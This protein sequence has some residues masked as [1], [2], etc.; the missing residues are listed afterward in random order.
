MAD[1]A[2]ARCRPGVLE[3]RNA[4]AVELRGM[5]PVERLRYI[6]QAQGADPSFVTCEAAEALVSLVATQPE[7]L[8]MACRRL[9]E[10]NLAVGPLWWLSARMLRSDE[11]EREG[12]EA[13]R[14]LAYDD[15]AR[16]LAD[17]LD[18]VGVAVVVGW[19]DV[20]A[21]ALRRRGDVEV[22][23]VDWDSQGAQFVRRLND[24]GCEATLVPAS[25]AATA[26]MVADVV[27]VEAFAAG[28]G[29][30]IATPGSLAAA[31][32]A[33][34]RQVPVWVVCGVGRVLP[35]ALWDTL[36]SCLDSSGAEPWDR[37]VELVPASLINAVVG[38]DG[39]TSIH[40]QAPDYAVGVEAALG[41]ST[42]PP[43]PELLRIS[44]TLPG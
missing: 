34:H 37:F 41:Y 16:H 5:N 22:L 4:Y 8:L 7:G 42:C 36:M 27:L 9:I 13:A 29:G 25:G 12:M 24:W 18:D 26:A 35:E 44:E 21:G 6:A 30:V 1:E 17:S 43:A 32:M 31:A 39:G 15:T 19:P 2:T 11:P 3:P 38:P 28:P 14:E 20:T 23:V 10:H 40:I 33:R